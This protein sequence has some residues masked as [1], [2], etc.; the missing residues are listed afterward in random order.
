MRLRPEAAVCLVTGWLRVACFLGVPSRYTELHEYVSSTNLIRCALLHVRL[1]CCRDR[2]TSLLW[3]IFTYVSL[4]HSLAQAPVCSPIRSCSPLASSHR[5][6]PPI[7]QL[8]TSCLPPKPSSQVCPAK[9]KKREGAAGCGKIPQAHPFDL[10]FFLF[11]HH[12]TPITGYL[13]N[14]GLYIIQGTG[15]I[16]YAD[17]CLALRKSMF[18]HMSGP[19]SG[20]PHACLNGLSR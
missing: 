9:G 8:V 16:P 14:V 2:E 7:P 17:C 20:E 4:M 11:H 19:G 10:L 6:P 3:T 1:S 12:T 15:N 5:P 13:L 18:Y